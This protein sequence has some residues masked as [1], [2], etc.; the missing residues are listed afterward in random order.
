MKDEIK[1]I[2]KGDISSRNSKK[3]S[4]GKFVVGEPKTKGATASNSAP[5]RNSGTN[6]ESQDKK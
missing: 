5:T 1:D 2:K 6:Q 4:D 3:A